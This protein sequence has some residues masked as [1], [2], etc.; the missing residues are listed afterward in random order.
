M[1]KPI[2]R[3]AGAV[4]KSP[5][6]QACWHTLCQQACSC[7]KEFDRVTIRRENWIETVICERI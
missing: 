1:Y 6:E 7:M 3:A 5:K 2:E 4:K